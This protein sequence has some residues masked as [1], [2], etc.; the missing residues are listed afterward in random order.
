MSLSLLAPP[1]E[2]PVALDDAK[3]WLKLDQDTDDD[4]VRALIVAARLQVEALTG[5]VLVTQNWRLTLDCWPPGGLVSVPLAPVA[6]L[7]AAAVIAGDGTAIAIDPATVTLDAASLPP[8]LLALDRPA[9]RGFAG[10]RFDLVAGYG[11]AADVPAPLVEAMR[12]M[13]GHW[14]G[15]RDELGTP[16]AEPAIPRAASALLAPY[17]LPRL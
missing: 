16:G 6:S 11:G 15:H 12:L 2:E 8:R 5:R 13:I 10:I 3:G 1:A 14:Y 17:R 4:L 9:S 7:A